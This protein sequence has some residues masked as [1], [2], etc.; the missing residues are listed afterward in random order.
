MR[1][2]F[3]FILSMMEHLMQFKHKSIVR[4]A[5]KSTAQSRF[6]HPHFLACG[7]VSLSSPHRCSL[8]TCAHYRMF[9]VFYEHEQETYMMVEKKNNSCLPFFHIF[10]FFFG[11]HSNDDVWICNHIAMCHAPQSIV[12]ACMYVFFI[13]RDDGGDGVSV[14]GKSSASGYDWLISFIL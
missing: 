7:V 11:R 14:W 13:L 4:M 5:P 3:H 9:T 2:L 8:P 6:F 10:F 1:S 12:C